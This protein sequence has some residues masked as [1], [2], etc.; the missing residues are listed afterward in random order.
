MLDLEVYP[1]VCAQLL[2]DC[3]FRGMSTG[4]VW[5]PTLLPFIRS[6]GSLLQI[7]SLLDEGIVRQSRKLEEHLIE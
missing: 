7:F 3:D 6:P 2:I 4:S 5:Q 1:F